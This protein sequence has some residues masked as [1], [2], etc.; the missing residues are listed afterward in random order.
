MKKSD[1]NPEELW[2]R[3]EKLERQNKRIKQIGILLLVLA[4]SIFVMGQARAVRSIE[5]TKFVLKN[6]KGKKRAELGFRLDGPELAFYDDKEKTLLSIGLLEDGPS[7]LV[8]DSQGKK[9]A[10][11]GLTLTG[12]MLSL[13]DQNGNRRLNLSVTAAGPA[14][15]LLGATGEAKAALGLTG[16]ESPF[17]QLFGSGER[18][19]AQLV[20]A[21]DMAVLRFLD[22][23][24]KPR[25]V[26]GMLEREAAPGII[27]ND[28]SGA[29]RSVL[30]LNPKGAALDFLNEKKEVTWHAP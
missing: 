25:A 15:G 4:G 21:P 28:A 12:P 11:F 18:S 20:A 9:M 7:L 1:S 26:F 14:V 17:L 24:E 13:S 30:M 10:S 23:A 22:S 16:A 2:L 5:S 6:A 3:V 8:W 27:L 19:G 29:T